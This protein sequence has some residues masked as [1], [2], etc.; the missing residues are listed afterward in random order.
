VRDTGV[1][2]PAEDLGRLFQPFSQVDPST[3]RKYGGT[4]LGLAIS[5]RICE[6]MGGSMTVQSTPGQG[7]T[8][9]FTVLVEATPELKSGAALADQ[10]PLLMGRL[11]LVVDDN[12]TN[13]AIVAEYART[14][15]MLVS[16]T[17]SP[18]E[19]LA[20]IQRGDPFDLAL[21]DAVMPEMDGTAL[22]AEIRKERDAQTLP[23]L[24]FSTLGRRDLGADGVD[25]A[26]YVS[27]PLKPSNLLDVTMNVLT[28]RPARQ[29]PVADVTHKPSDGSMAQRFPL[30][31]LVAEDNAVNQK[32]ALRLLGQLGYNA[33]VAA[34]GLEVLAA[35]ERQR[36]DVVL[37]D[38]QMPELDGLDAARRICQ[39]WQRAERPRIV[40]MT[41]N[42]MQGDREVCL[43]AGMDDYISKPI[44]LGE[45]VAALGRSDVE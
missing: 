25:F 4:G 41:A 14:W 35:L 24:L 42:A 40:A 3:S 19:A 9:S 34:D 17:S 13:R 30:R 23:L 29:R 39:R 5:R 21:L 43:D 44:H 10:Q 28:G 36:Y 27:K 18:T 26:G 2:I 6:L 20:W 12:D 16:E 31:I 8:F 22:A 45:L 11:L 7:T 32:L 15:G 1:G 33:D 37:M 38:V